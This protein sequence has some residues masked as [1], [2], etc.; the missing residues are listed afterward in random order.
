VFSC[1]RD[2]LGHGLLPFF[3]A[4]ALAVRKIFPICGKVVAEI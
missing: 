4:K 3:R 2:R 1:Q